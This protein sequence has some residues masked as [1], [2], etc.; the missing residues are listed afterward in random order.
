[1]FFKRLVTAAICFVLLFCFFYVG[2][3]FLIG[4]VVGVDTAVEEQ[5]KAS[6]PDA[7][8]IKEEAKEKARAD[9]EGHLRII[10]LT[11]V[12]LAGLSSLVLAF[13]GL[14]PWCRQQ[15]P[16]VVGSDST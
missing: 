12:V 13:G 4:F 11:A 15:P 10:T 16:A 9:V 3:S 8:K 7:A 1:M 14:L 6:P 2:G 5:S